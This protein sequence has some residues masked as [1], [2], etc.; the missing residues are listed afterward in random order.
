MARDFSA[1]ITPNSVSVHL[2]N[3]RSFIWTA[4]DTDFARVLKLVNDP[5]TTAAV[6][7][8]EMD[9]KTTITK[10]LRNQPAG[11]QFTITDTDVLHNGTPLRLGIAKRIV[12]IAKL[13]LDVSAMLAFLGNLLQNPRFS[14]VNELYG[15]MDACDLPITDDGCFIAYKIVRHDFHDLY[16]GKFDN[17]VGKV[18]EMQASAVDDNRNNTCSQGLHVCSKG[19]LP[20]YGGG[21]SGIT[22][23]QGNHARVMIVKVNPAHVVSVPV[24]Y[25]NAKMRVWKY[26]VVGEITSLDELAKI[27]GAG[28]FGGTKLNDTW[29][30]DGDGDADYDD[31]Y[32]NGN[33]GD[34]ADDV[35]DDHGNA[36]N[37][38]DEAHTGPFFVQ[39]DFDEDRFYPATVGDH[40]EGKTLYTYDTAS[41]SYERV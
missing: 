19:Y 25:N 29:A 16:S 31:S 23:R 6:I 27:E 1:R 35:T 33:C 28:V 14:A 10:A 3:G 4:D 36:V 34:T 11:S 39:D 24:D 5:K 15:F 8:R 37:E 12:E 18:C 32:D 20:H 21:M 41:N 26:E 9:A 2:Y 17:S 38:A 13:G 22:S 30:D 7:T 40:R